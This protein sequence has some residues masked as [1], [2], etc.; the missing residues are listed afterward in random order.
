MLCIVLCNMSLKFIQR[1]L[2]VRN[3]NIT[4]TLFITLNKIDEPQPDVICKFA[5]DCLIRIRYCAE[6]NVSKLNK[7]EKDIGSLN[8]YKAFFS[9]RPSTSESY[10]ISE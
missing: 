8:R 6:F 2:L 1:D 5:A 7:L 3:K 9:L 10:G 4:V